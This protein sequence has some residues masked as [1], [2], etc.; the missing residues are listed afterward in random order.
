MTSM[1]ALWH[2]STNLLNSSLFFSADSFERYSK[3]GVNQ[4]IGLYPQK[5]FR[6]LGASVGSKQKIGSNSIV[7]IPSSLR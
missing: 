7:V 5:F 4:L 2:S 6:P 1:S 3:C